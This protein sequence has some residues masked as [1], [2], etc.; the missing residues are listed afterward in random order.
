ME[1]IIVLVVLLGLSCAGTV[2]REK[3]QAATNCVEPTIGNPCSTNLGQVYFPH[4]TDN[5]K[6]LQCAQGGRMFIIKCPSGE[7]Y[8]QATTSCTK[9]QVVTPVVTTTTN[10][11]TAANLAA[12]KIFFPY[13]NDNTKFIECN[14]L[15]QPQVLSCPSR[16][17]YSALRQ[18][19][20]L[21]EGQTGGTGTGTGGVSTG[22]GIGG[23]TVT[24]TV[25]NP[26]TGGTG[27]LSNPCPGVITDVNQ[28]L[29]FPHPDKYKFI[30]CDLAG[31]YFI[32]SCPAGLIWND[33][34][35]ICDSP[36]NVNFGTGVS[37]TVG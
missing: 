2:V 15:G 22:T 10:P 5:T 26:G 19:C 33:R 1:R 6:F 34:L 36:Y 31:D 3:R 7:V 25:I 4:P 32:M 35:K 29:L 23:G 30:Q 16:L 28:N 17:V 18:S 21:P 14:R 13:P 11:C 12:G 24:G 8:N 27:T 20:L 37:G 9:P